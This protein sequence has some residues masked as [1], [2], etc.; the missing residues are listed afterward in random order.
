MF[1]VEWE[2]WSKPQV[3]P[4]W[5][6]MRLIISVALYLLA[7]TLLLVG[8][9]ER[10]VWA[11]KDSKEISVSID[12]PQP[13]LVVPHEILKLNP[14]QPIIKVNG[15]GRVFVATGRES[16][17]SAWVGGSA[18]S[19]VTYN[20]KT[21]KLGSSE[22]FGLAASANPNGSDLWRTER[23]ANSEVLVKVE[24][25]EENAL[26]IASDGLAAAPN[27]VTI[28]WHRDYDLT[29]SNI[30]INSGFVLLFITLIYNFLVFRNLR[31]TRRPRRKLP[32]APHGPR[33]RP[34]RRSS[35]LPPRGRRSAR[36]T[37]A[38]IPASML[39]IS[40]VTGCTTSS[41]SV[42]PTPTTTKTNIAEQP[43]ALQ[44]GQIRRIVTAVSRIAKAA[45][46]ANAATQLLP[47]FAGPALEMR[48][49]A[50]GLLKKT[51]K[52]PALEPIYASPLTLSLPAATSDWPRILMVATG[53]KKD[54]APQMLVLRQ[55]EP[56]KQ[57]QVV[58]VATLASGVKLPEVPAVTEGAVPVTPD[59]AYLTLAPNDLPSAYG[60]LIDNGSSST[61]F[62]SFELA[63]DKFYQT[64]SVEQ[65][66]Q[67]DTLKKAKLTYQHVMGDAIPIGLATADGGALVAV[68]MKDIT[69]IKPTKRN[70][71]ITVNELQ[72]VALGAKGSLKGVVTT[73]GD[74]LLFYVPSVGQDAKVRLLGWQTG[75]L[76]VK[77][78]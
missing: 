25:S 70:S 38:V 12:G 19:L 32:R 53:N 1:C 47:R 21:K 18:Q 8:I 71:G 42:T 48:D 44:I 2:G 63:G 55:D 62:G 9:A 60:S 73:Y 58:Y 13:L 22:I 68:Y 16:D 31:N 67:V 28:K 40:M 26:I 37:F 15:P 7:L 61:F 52:A 4:D 75:L 10:T 33:S 41:Q 45:D 3:Y 66:K 6:V 57:Y 59:S 46:Q 69:T 30:L 49:A 77:S 65:K 5:I 51:K 24:T 43:P 76:K 74:M 17:I 23:A 29:P 11:P 78:L 72:Q 36:R 50:Y 34:K 39:M 54:T 14:G 64:L 20:K 27:E 35:S 56:R